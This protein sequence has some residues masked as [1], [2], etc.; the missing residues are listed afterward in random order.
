[1]TRRLDRRWPTGFV[2]RRARGAD[3]RIVEILCKLAALSE[4]IGNAETAVERLE[5]GEDARSLMQS[6]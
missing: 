1:M 3:P 5:R 6:L 4:A 2:E